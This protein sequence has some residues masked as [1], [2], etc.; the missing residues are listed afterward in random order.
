MEKLT[1]GSLFSGIGGF[2]LAAEWM[3][4]DNLFHC[5]W[6]VFGKKVLNYY[7]PD[8]VQ[9]DD[10]T[11]TDFSVW[12][13]RVDVLTG[14]FPC[15]P[16]SLAGKRLG[17]EDERQL[18]PHMLRAIREIRPRY[19]VGENVYGIIN[20]NG[21]LVFDE[22]QSDLEAEGFA[23]QAVVLPAAS[24]NAPHKRDRTWFVAYSDKFYG[25]LSGLRAGE[26]PQFKTPEICK[27][28]HPNPTGN[29]LQRRSNG[30][31]LRET[32]PNGDKRFENLGRFSGTDWQDFPTQPPVCTGD[33]GLPGRLDGIT[34]SKWRSESIKAAGNAIVPQVALE[35][36][37][38]I[39]MH[40]ELMKYT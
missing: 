2:D 28:T 6:N 12:R 22:V 31:I 35:L 33:D 5:E 15:Q 11:K 38:V 14:G 13:G 23:V 36:F 25:D 40:D 8:A 24:V 30:R 3:G 39:S 34:F 10:I 27:H 1:H 21:G 17:K 26:I 16:Y 9:F 7:W 32:G 4:W 19:V 37:K 18:W 29:G 20:W